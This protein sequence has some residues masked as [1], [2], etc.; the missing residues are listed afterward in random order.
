MFNTALSGLEIAFVH[1]SDRQKTTTVWQPDGNVDYLKGK[2]IP[3]FILR[4]AFCILALLYTF[5]LLFIQC[6]QKRSNVKCFC[7]IERQKPFFEAHTGPCHIHYRFWPGCLLFA[8][9]TILTLCSLLID[10]N[11]PNLYIIITACVVIQIIAFVLP[12]RVYKQWPLNVL[13]ST[14]ILNL[15]VIAGLLAIFCHTNSITS[16]PTYQSYYFVYPSVTLTMV[17]FACILSYHCVKQLKS[18]HWF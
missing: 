3:L 4:T 11:H 12:N 8:R 10:R 14:F 17:S 18:Y 15:G 9:I 6:L 5:A 2:H 16:Q 1:H 13:E 7:W